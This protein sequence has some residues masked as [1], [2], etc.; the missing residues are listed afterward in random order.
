MRNCVF[1]FKKKKKEKEWST[2]MIWVSLHHMQMYTFVYHY[3]D[4]VTHVVW[5]QIKYHIHHYQ[6]ISLP[7]YNHSTHHLF[8]YNFLFI[9]T[10]AFV[11]VMKD[12]SLIDICLSCV[13]FYPTWVAPK[14]RFILC[15]IINEPTGGK[16]QC[17]FRSSRK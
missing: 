17:M 11:S 13:T 2:E 7:L 3:D 1:F 8:N 15:F 14:K 10:I 9:I 6:S 16:Y 5:F 4:P 12:K